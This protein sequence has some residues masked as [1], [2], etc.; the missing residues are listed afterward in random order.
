M[1]QGGGGLP[2]VSAFHAATSS[3]Q[4]L[5][6]NVDQFRTRTAGEPAFASITASCATA[7]T[8]RAPA[9]ASITTSGAPAST[10]GAP[11]SMS[12]TASCASAAAAAERRHVR[13]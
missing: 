11:A 5:L 12:I 1:T 7:A 6:P 4:F 9:C 2:G 13:P 10:A 8:V 3:T